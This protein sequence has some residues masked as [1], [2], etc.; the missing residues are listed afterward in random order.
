MSRFVLVAVAVLV[1][2]TAA[3]WTRA[4]G[5][6]VPSDAQAGIPSFGEF[7]AAIRSVEHQLFAPLA[8]SKMADVT[9]ETIV[10]SDRHSTQCKHHPTV[11]AFGVSVV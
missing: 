6:T 3:T 8:E 4:A 7:I 11:A 1:T 10:S 5:G 2:V 9:T